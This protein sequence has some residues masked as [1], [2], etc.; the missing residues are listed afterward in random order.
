M[1]EGR[2]LESEPTLHHATFPLSIRSTAMEPAQATCL[3]LWSSTAAC[4]RG[5]TRH[6]RKER[7]VKARESRTN[8]ASGPTGPPV[9]TKNTTHTGWSNEVKSEQSYNE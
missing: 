5:C 4:T 3:T 9:R 7:S 1:I 8:D 6:E 2:H